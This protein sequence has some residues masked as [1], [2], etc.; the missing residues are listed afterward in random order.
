[1][2]LYSGPLGKPQPQQPGATGGAATFFFFGDS[3]PLW[4]LAI[5]TSP[6]SPE[7]NY[8]QLA[9]IRPILEHEISIV[10]SHEQTEESPY[11]TSG[12]KTKTYAYNITLS[13]GIYIGTLYKGMCKV[14]CV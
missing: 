10:N 4:A 5:I 12:I 11:L 8:Q 7:L 13:L 3:V 2:S 9:K 1:L 14:T 6:W